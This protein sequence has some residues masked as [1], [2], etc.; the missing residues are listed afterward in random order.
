M[1]AIP[2]CF[3]EI[4]NSSLGHQVNQMRC[5][6]ENHIGKEIGLVNLTGFGARQSDPDHDFIFL[7]IREIV[8]RAIPG[9]CLLGEVS[10]PVGPQRAV[11]DKKD[12]DLVAF[13]MGHFCKLE[14]PR[15]QVDVI[16][17]ES[18]DKFCHFRL[19]PYVLS[20]LCSLSAAGPPV[21]L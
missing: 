11:F 14:T 3:S 7:K 1:G 13:L 18:V 9:D 19:L 5:T 6:V 17:A 4:E 20:V 10:R 21:N 15:R 12:V 8:L 2:A 16:F